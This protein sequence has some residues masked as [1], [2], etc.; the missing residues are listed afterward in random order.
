MKTTFEVRRIDHFGEFSRDFE[1]RTGFNAHFPNATAYYRVV[2]QVYGERG[3]DSI[4]WYT[5]AEF[6]TSKIEGHFA[7]DGEAAANA[8]AAALN[9]EGDAPAIASHKLAAALQESKPVLKRSLKKD[10]VSER[11]A[12]KHE[13]RLDQWERDAAAIAS[14]YKEGA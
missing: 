2:A 5:V 7:T 4:S 13:G 6:F 11:I 9:Q 14:L 10:I 8:C 1:G 12:L 3:D